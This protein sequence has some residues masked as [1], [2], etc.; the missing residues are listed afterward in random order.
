MA[1]GYYT[2]H[3]FPYRLSSTHKWRRS[4]AAPMKRS[5]SPSN[6]APSVDGSAPATAFGCT[7]AASLAPQTCL[8]FAAASRQRVKLVHV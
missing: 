7:V 1:I 5:A 6:D 8:D 2:T 4:T 3:L